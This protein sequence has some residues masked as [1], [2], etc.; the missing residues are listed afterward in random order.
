MRRVL[1]AV[2][3]AA[4]AAVGGCGDECSHYSKFSC[5][6][7]QKADYNVFFYV[8]SRE[9]Y[10]GRASGLAQCGSMARARLSTMQRTP[11]DWSYICCMIAKGSSCY[12]K[13]R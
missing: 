5:D 9:E 1:R 7:I 8:A 11:A 4:C 12:E 6:Q 2:L 3:L 13:H 10:L